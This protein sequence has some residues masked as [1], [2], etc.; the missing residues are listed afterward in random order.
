MKIKINK[1]L[2][3]NPRKPPLI[4]AE[5]SANHCGKKSLFLDHIKS[6]AKNGADLIKIQTYEPDDITVENNKYKIK[7]GIWRSKTLWSIYKKACTPF[8]WHKDAFKLA[9]KIGVTLFS[10]PFSIRAVDLLEKLNCPIFKIA[11]F[12]ITDLKL[13]KYIASKKKPIILSTGTAEIK[14]IKTALKLINKF[15]NKVIILHCV[16]SYPTNEENAQVKKINLLKK[17]F[18]NNLIGISD[19]TS[20]I[21]SSLAAAALGS[22]VIEKH[23]KISSKIKS[24][25]SK[26][27]ITPDQLKELK[28]G[29]IKIFNTLGNF[30]NL[31]LKV[32]KKS[33]YFRRSIYAKKD[34]YRGEKINDKNIICLRPKVGIGAEYYFKI[35]GKKTNIDIKKNF[36]I[37]RKNII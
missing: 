9:K 30:S 3:I 32:D 15:H 13:I 8:A 19:H 28:E 5:I 7:S 4:I 36:P 12:E 11:S 14:E 29:S 25:D 16:S 24:P 6:A 22:A 2:T 35:I 31:K 21:N 33:I 17:L 37:F 20:N 1:K 18:K 27:S 10:S 23:F 34:I 26:F